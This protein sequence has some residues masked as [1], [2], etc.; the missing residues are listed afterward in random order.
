MPG[1]RT[2]PPVVGPQHHGPILEQRQAGDRPDD[3]AGGADKVLLRPRQLA[4]VAEDASKHIC[5]TTVCIWPSS[6]GSS[7]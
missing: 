4:A 6:G 2:L 1:M 3:E 5:I 7:G